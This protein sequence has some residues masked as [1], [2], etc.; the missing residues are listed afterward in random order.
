MPDFFVKNNVKQSTASIGTPV[1]ADPVYEPIASFAI[2]AS[3]QLIGKIWITKNGQKM[4]NDLGTASFEFIDN[5]GA[6][7]AGLTESG[8]T[9]NADGDFIITPVSA[10]SILDLSHYTVKVDVSADSSLRRGQMGIPV[11]N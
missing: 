9:A 4:Y 5:S 3:N 6:P 10:A 7:V 8:L 2:N 11:G 1:V